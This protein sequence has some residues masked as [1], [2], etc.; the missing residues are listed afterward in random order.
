MM[1]HRYDDIGLKR[2]FQR[3]S[4]QSW[5]KCRINLIGRNHFHREG[6]FILVLRPLTDHG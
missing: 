1:P 4:E 5:F 2:G 3:I 6:P